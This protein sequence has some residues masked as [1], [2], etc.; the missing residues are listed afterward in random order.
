MV[1][2]VANPRVKD[3]LMAASPLAPTCHLVVIQGEY[4]Y[5][6]HLQPA[7]SVSA[8]GSEGR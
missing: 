4:E 1:L 3:G 6:E 5:W 8:R 2:R 7:G